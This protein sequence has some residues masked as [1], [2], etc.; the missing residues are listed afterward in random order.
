MLADQ[1][2]TH[3]AELATAN[4]RIAELEGNTGEP[5]ADPPKPA[6][7]PEADSPELIKAR[8]DA[9][10]AAEAQA[11]AESKLSAHE[12]TT[13]NIATKD[14]LRGMLKTAGVAED[15]LDA[16][17]KLLAAEPGLF[18]ATLNTTGG[19]DLK[20]ADVKHTG[21]EMVAGW[22]TVNAWAVGTMPA[23]GSAPAGPGQLVAGAGLRDQRLPPKG[24]NLREQMAYANRY[25][26]QKKANT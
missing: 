25:D 8:A 17:A 13:L 23:A 12:L 26:A 1:K 3:A 7:A 21:T 24:L 10:A 4:A 19:A 22:L 16:A 9:A 18:A 15:R 14:A 20:P 2:A 6:A 5:P 11:L